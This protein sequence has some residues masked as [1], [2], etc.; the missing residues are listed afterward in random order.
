M[1]DEAVVL[2]DEALELMLVLGGLLLVG[3]H[4]LAG[5]VDVVTSVFKSLL[6]H[7]SSLLLLPQSLL[8]FV[9]E[10]AVG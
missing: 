5:T 9:Q 8:K 1:L 6:G 10:L 4:L 2:D 3:F 7:L